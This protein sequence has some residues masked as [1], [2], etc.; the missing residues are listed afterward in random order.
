MQFDALLESLGTS[1]LILLLHCNMVT[2][3]AF[4]NYNGSSAFLPVMADPSSQGVVHNSVRLIV[5]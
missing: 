2:G 5:C 4:I 1:I 3:D